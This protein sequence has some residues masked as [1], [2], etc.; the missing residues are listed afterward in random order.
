MRVNKSRQ[1]FSFLG[2][3]TPVGAKIII[4]VSHY[5]HGSYL[6]CLSRLKLSHSSQRSLVI[7]V[8]QKLVNANASYSAPCGTAENAVLSILL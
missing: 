4:Q 2:E 6:T 7:F 8:L 5:K 3:V 1:E